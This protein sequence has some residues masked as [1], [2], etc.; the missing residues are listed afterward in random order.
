MMPRPSAAVEG[1]AGRGACTYYVQIVK[2]K[3]KY[4]KKQTNKLK[5]YKI[6]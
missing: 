1:E 2:E 4:T 6:R 3:R 5:K